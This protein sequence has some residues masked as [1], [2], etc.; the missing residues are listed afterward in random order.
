MNEPVSMFT[1]AKKMNLNYSSA[2]KI[3]NDYRAKCKT[4]NKRIFED[5]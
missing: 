1:L 5:L 2:K 3:I 4:L